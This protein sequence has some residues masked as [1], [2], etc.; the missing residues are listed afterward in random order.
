MRSRI[1]SPQRW[2][3]PTYTEN[4]DPTYTETHI[5]AESNRWCHSS[6]Q[7]GSGW[8]LSS[9][10]F[11]IYRNSLL[12]RVKRSAAGIM[13]P[14]SHDIS[15]PS[16]HLPPH[17]PTHSPDSYAW[18][19]HCEAKRWVNVYSIQIESQLLHEER[20][21]LYTMMGAKEDKMWS[22]SLVLTAL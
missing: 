22:Y 10:P 2:S 12:I 20:M 18:K 5:H 13:W 16:H 17:A 7:A 15:A 6:R 8:S 21:N 11:S 9:G 19:C 14:G 1:L 3:D 4:S